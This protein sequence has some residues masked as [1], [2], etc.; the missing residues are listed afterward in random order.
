MTFGQALAWVLGTV[1]A[2]ALIFA[3]GWAALTLDARRNEGRR[4]R[5]TPAPAERVWVA[6]L[7]EPGRSEPDPSDSEYLCG[8][9]SPVRA[10]SRCLGYRCTLPTDH[11]GDHYAEVDGRQVATWGRRS[12]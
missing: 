9:F 5:D 6:D 3:A 12:D 1:L 7:T 4:Q 11:P 2:T 8:A 10:G